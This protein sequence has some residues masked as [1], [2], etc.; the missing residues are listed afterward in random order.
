MERNVGLAAL[1]SPSVGLLDDGVVDDGRVRPQEGLLDLPICRI[2]D[3]LR[4]R[5][6]I[7]SAQ[8]RR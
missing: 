3:V 4:A 1:T 8:V 5:E 6:D 7:S 2:Q